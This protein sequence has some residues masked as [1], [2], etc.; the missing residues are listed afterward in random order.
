MNFIAQFR[1]FDRENVEDDYLEDEDDDDEE[2]AASDIEFE[3]VIQEAD[4]EPRIGNEVE[5][6]TEELVSVPFSP[7]SALESAP[8]RAKV[9]SHDDP[10]AQFRTERQPPVQTSLDDYLLVCSCFNDIVML[11]AQCKLVAQLSLVRRS[12]PRTGAPSIY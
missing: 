3:N 5:V 4:I 12:Q 10:L 8:K 6:D 1:F 9:A 2:I 11:D 7:D